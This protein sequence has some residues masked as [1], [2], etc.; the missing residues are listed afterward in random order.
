MSYPQTV[1]SVSWHYKNP[2]KHIGLVQSRH[3]HQNVICSHHVIAGKLLTKIK[4]KTE[5]YITNELTHLWS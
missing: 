3:H 4:I 2:N 1:V 5:R